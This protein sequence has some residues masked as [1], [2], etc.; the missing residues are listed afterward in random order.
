MSQKLLCS[1]II[2]ALNE[3]KHIEKC[4]SALK[5]QSYPKEKYEIIVIDNGS[6]DNTRTIAEQ[7]ADQ[8]ILLRT[9]NVGAVRNYGVKK[10]SGEIIVF[11]DADCVID[12]TWLE[13]AIQ[14]YSFETETVLGGIC[15]C[16]ENPNWIEKYWL[17]ETEK[18]C[19]RENN[20]LGA[21][22][23]ISRENFEQ[24]GGFREEMSSGEDSALTK[25]LR[26]HGFIVKITPLLK[27]VHLGNAT[28][29]KEF[30]NRQSWHAESYLSKKGENLSD[31]VFWLV[32]VYPITLILPLFLSL[33]TISYL[34]ML[35]MTQVPPAILSAKRIIRS[36]YK[37]RLEEAIKILFLDNL[38][39]IGRNQ[40]ILKSIFKR[41]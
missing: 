25:D 6:S 10:S 39:L 15:V 29:I 32:L 27:V 33:A 37:P 3:G 11:L 35:L 1:I 19:V 24:V 31:P 23:I 40:G 28:T 4:L 22:I 20:L 16:R 12:E 38:Y 41:S 13:R 18:D 21:C 14:M 30:L 8:V 36:G 7:Y 26:D 5:A 2:P 17:L 9:G 34:P